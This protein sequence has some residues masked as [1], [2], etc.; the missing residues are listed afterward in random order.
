MQE[1]IAQLRQQLQLAGHHYHV[2]DEPL[3]PDAEYDR[4]FRELQALEADYPQ[5]I[6]PDSPTQR[7]GAQPM[8][9]FAFIPRP[10]SA[11]KARFNL[12]PGFEKYCN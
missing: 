10:I 7:V 11:L 5:W 12:T 2:L 1:R 6:T 8:S 9:A 3:I 4:L